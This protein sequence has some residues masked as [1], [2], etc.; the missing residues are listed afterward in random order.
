MVWFRVFGLSLLIAATWGLENTRA[1]SKIDVH[2]TS[3]ASHTLQSPRE[4]GSG[5]LAYT[6]LYSATEQESRF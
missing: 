5:N 1:K 3:L 4:R 2:M 6:E